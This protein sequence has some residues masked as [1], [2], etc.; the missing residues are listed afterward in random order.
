MEAEK[1]NIFDKANTI[2]F[3]GLRR[4]WNCWRLKFA[5]D[6]DVWVEA[7]QTRKGRTVVLSVGR[8]SVDGEPRRMRWYRKLLEQGTW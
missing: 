2:R 5:A 6:G 8:F 4:I 3:G 7:Y 1:P